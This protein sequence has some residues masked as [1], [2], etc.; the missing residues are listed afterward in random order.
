MGSTERAVDRRMQTYIDAMFDGRILF[1]ALAGP[2]VDL[3]VFDGAEFV[4]EGLLYDD[5][6]LRGLARRGRPPG[7]LSGT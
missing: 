3:E 7:P 1:G 5:G 2:K 6:V 4:R